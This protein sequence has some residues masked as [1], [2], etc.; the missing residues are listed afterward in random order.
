MHLLKHMKDTG[1]LEHYTLEGLLL[2]LEK[3]KKIRLANGEVITT[4]ISKWQ[5]MI[6]ETL[7][8][9]AKLTRRSGSTEP[10]SR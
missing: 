10:V 8:V 6:L 1:L 4:E 2:E 9:C 3:I 7:R 5:R